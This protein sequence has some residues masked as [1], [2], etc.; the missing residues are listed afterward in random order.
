MN[1]RGAFRRLQ[2]VQGNQPKPWT[3][4]QHPIDE[5]GIMHLSNQSLLVIVLVGIIAGWLAGRVMDGGGLG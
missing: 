4:C 5:E 2:Q 3:L 1:R